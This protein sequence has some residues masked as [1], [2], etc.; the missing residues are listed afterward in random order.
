MGFEVQ[1]IVGFGLQ[2]FKVSNK[3]IRL[4]AF[5]FYERQGCASLTICSQKT[6]AHSLIVDCKLYWLGLH[7]HIKMIFTCLIVRNYNGLAEEESGHDY[8]N[9]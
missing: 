6:Q 9:A 3:T 1:N 7:S 5:I 4:L 2:S 8:L